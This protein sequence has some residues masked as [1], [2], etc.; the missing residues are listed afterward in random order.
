MFRVLGESGRPKVTILT[1]SDLLQYEIVRA[2][3]Q[4]CWAVRSHGIVRQI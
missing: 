3:G 1:C 2:L 4:N